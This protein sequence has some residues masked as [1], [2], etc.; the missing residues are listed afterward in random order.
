MGLSA[1]SD[2]IPGPEVIWFNINTPINLGKSP[3]MK[4]SLNQISLKNSRVIVARVPAII[5]LRA[6]RLMSWNLDIQDRI[7]IIFIPG[8]P[9][10]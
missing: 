2:Y 1:R 9:G 3:G 10:Q 6:R 4:P 8:L 5:P 7:I